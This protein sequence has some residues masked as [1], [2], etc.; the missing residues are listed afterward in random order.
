MALGKKT[1]GRKKG[2]PNRGVSK[3]YKVKLPE[4]ITPLDYLLCVMRSEDLSVTL[5]HRLVAA[6]AAAPYC[7]RALKAIE[8]TGEGG[9]PVEQKVILSFD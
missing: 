1:G 4:G 7:H 5:E 3:P 9:G 2:T 8:L 6:K